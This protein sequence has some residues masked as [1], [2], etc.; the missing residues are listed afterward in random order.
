M[1]LDELQVHV[2]KHA[3]QQFCDRVGPMGREELSS[4]CADHLERGE[5]EREDEYLKMGDIWWVFDVN[6]DRLTLV[7]CYGILNV[8]LPAALRWARHHNDRIILTRGGEVL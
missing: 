3:H 7:T 8:D 5:Y 4:A 1:R 2:S 6:G